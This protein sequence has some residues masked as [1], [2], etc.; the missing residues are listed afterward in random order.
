MVML[1]LRVYLH[2]IRIQVGSV[3]FG[4]HA[5]PLASLVFHLF[6]LFVFG[7]IA[8]I[9]A[10]VLLIKRF[11][12]QRFFTYVT[13]FIYLLLVIPHI[14]FA[15][16]LPIS[17]HSLFVYGLLMLPLSPMEGLIMFTWKKVSGLFSQRTIE[18][19]QAE[20]AQRRHAA[21]QKHMAQAARK[22][23]LQP[24][25]A[26]DFINVGVKIDGEE[27]PAYLGI[28][29]QNEWVRIKYP[30]F[31]HH[32]FVVG[33]TGAGK[34]NLLLRIIY[35]TLH[36]TRLRIY[37]IDGK[38][39]LAFAK[40]I[41]NLA[42]QHGRG[43]VPIF[44]MGQTEAARVSASVYDGF[45]GDRE[46][47]ANRLSMMMS[48]DKTVGNALHYSETYKGLMHLI[49]G[50]GYPE[51][52]IKPPKNFDDVLGRLSFNWLSQTYAKIPSELAVIKLA[53]DGREDLIAAASARLGNLARPLKETVDTTGFNLEDS[54]CAIFSLR[55][56]SVGVDAKQFLNFLIEDV[57]DWVGKRQPPDVEALLI[58]DEFGSF[59]NESINEVLTLARSSKV[60]VILSTQD[61]AQLGDERAKRKI[62]AN[63]NTYFLMK[64]NFP[65]ELVN[66]AGTIY[67]VEP[68]F[69]IENGL[70]TGMQ[71]ARI[72]HQFKIP[73]NDVAQVRPGQ[74]Y[75]INSRYAL[76]MQAATIEDAPTDEDAIASTFVKK[77]PEP[78]EA[79]TS[80]RRKK[81]DNVPEI[82]S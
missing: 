26:K 17:V 44:M 13:S 60:G 62:L 6:L 23:Q 2:D 27:F 36:N 15:K 43:P 10:L 30:Q 45:R 25:S 49:C 73:P 57:K 41:A 32:A 56:Q 74:C 46:A 7:P 77:K 59:N 82:P 20:Q 68:S 24:D 54:H 50:V 79:K 42:Y 55:T 63:C 16:F 22:A 67:A 76:K 61:V 35:E 52:G 39:D 5:P 40:T 51:L 64:T 78:A 66:L 38:G 4:Y 1:R 21:H 18:D 11:R 37:V 53:H 14:P 47:I 19:E 69:Q 81:K 9:V 12:W 31:F 3:I 8:Y 28:E 65:E 58:I 34:T 70:P 75:I 80:P 29:E 33:T 71:S 72:Q 48:V